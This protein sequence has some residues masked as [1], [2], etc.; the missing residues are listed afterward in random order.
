MEELR[1]HHF[2]L[3]R[4]SFLPLTTSINIWLVL[5][6]LIDLFES[7]IFTSDNLTLSGLL[8]TILSVMFWIT[9]YK[10]EWHTGVYSD[11]CF[12]AQNVKLGFVLFIVSEIM[13]FFSFFF[14]YFYN[15]IW[16]L[17][18]FFGFIWPAA[19]IPV[20][21]SFSVALPLTVLLLT[22]SGTI[23]VAILGLLVGDELLALMYT[24]FTIVLGGLFISIQFKEYN[25][26]IFGINDGI[27][28]SVFLMITGLH[29][30]H[31]FLGL[32][33]ISLCWVYFLNNSYVPTHSKKRGYVF[34]EVSAWY[35]HFVD[36]VWLLVYTW[37]YD[38]RVFYGVE[39]ADSY[40]ILLLFTN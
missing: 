29:G 22:S 40:K 33:M 14:L 2:Y 11:T 35:W 4:D 9:E 3:L 15:S 36:V 26:L 38:W 1:M 21:S 17:P 37:L 23:N 10:H 16:V 18:E 6:G 7:G 34:L 31:V 19:N 32:C 8:G 5:T 20:L 24:L 27:S 39:F 25:E 12:E 28:G 13:F 30:F